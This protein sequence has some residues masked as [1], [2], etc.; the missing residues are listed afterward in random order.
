MVN[1]VNNSRYQDDYAIV[2]K[3]IEDAKAKQSK[4][5]N[6]R[7]LYDKNGRPIK[8]NYPKEKINYSKSRPDAKSFENFNDKPSVFAKI[9][10]NGEIDAF[11][12][13]NKA[14][15]CYLLS[16]L[17]SLRNNPDTA[18][19]LKNNI[20]ENNDGSFTITF[21][22]AKIVK[23][24]NKENNIQ[25]YITGIYKI[26]PEEFYEARQS[27]RYSSGDDDVLLYELAFEKYRKEVKETDLVNNLPTNGN[28]SGIYTGKN[29]E[30]ILD[31]GIS[32][33][34]IFVLT[35]MQ[36]ERLHVKGNENAKISRWELCQTDTE[37]K[38]KDIDNINEYLEKLRKNPQ[39]YISTASFN[40]DGVRHSI[41]IKCVTD[42]DVVLVDTYNSERE[43]TMDKNE[44]VNKVRNIEIIDIRKNNQDSLLKRCF[45][46]IVNFLNII[47]EFFSNLF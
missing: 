47:G 11:K 36:G 17:I 32:T 9:N 14:G 3:M 42:K 37:L 44:F 35:G 24:N 39:D 10:S 38:E 5:N 12:Q 4:S 46:Q 23:D 15:D 28:R 16:S 18:K 2:A 43:I 34:A 31:F 27:G 8:Y 7:V 45:N 19:I 22:G 25:S 33:D 40:V 20:K 21:P 6:D 30:N 26:T 13:G 29:S 1:L 41:S